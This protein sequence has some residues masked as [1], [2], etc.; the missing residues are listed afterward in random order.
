M[1]PITV[2]LVV[3]AAGLVNLAVRTAGWEGLLRLLPSVEDQPLRG[4]SRRLDGR[5]LLGS[6]AV[7]LGLIPLL[8]GAIAFRM[9]GPVGLLL[10]VVAGLGLAR[11]RSR[12]QARGRAVALERQLGEVAETVGLALRS[13]LSVSQALEFASAEVDE[14]MAELLCR[15]ADERRLGIRFDQALDRLAETLGTEDARLFAL[16]VGIHARSGGD[17]AGALEEVT[18]SIRHRIAV[19]TELRALSTQGRVSGAIMGSLP[20]AFFAVLATTSRRQLA[21]VY[22]SSAGIAMLSAGLTMEGLA[23]LWIRRLLRIEE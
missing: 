21:P 17:L 20:I 9:V 2:V 11:L 3:S 22:R 19:R 10:G 12:R 23:Y 14:P 6:R 18:E 5:S 16:V 15:F 13:G 4:A 7:R 1:S 8:L